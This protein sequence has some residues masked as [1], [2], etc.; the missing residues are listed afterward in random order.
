MRVAAFVLAVVACASTPPASDAPKFMVKGVAQRSGQY[1]GG[2]AP[3]PEM[4]KQAQ[5][6]RVTTERFDVLR[7]KGADG[8]LVTSFNPDTKGQFSVS[9]PPGDYCVTEAGKREVPKNG[10]GMYVDAA[11]MKQWR[12]S[13]S[14]VWHVDAK[15]ID[16]SFTLA[17]PCFGPCYRGPMPPAAAPHR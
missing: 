11:C 1:C 12:A 2:A 17:S 13:C 7:G 5:T 15:D 8:E 9:L 4:I 16:G 3:S 6:P 14:L 10:D